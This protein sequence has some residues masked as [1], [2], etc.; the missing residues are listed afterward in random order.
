M[1]PRLAIYDIET[2]VKIPH[3][4]LPTQ[5][6]V[7]IVE[8]DGEIINFSSY[9]KCKYPLSVTVERFN[10][11]TDE[12]LEKEGRPLYDVLTEFH[13]LINVPGTLII[14]HNIHRFD[15][16]VCNTQFNQIG[17]S[18]IHKNQCFDTMAQRKAELLG[19]IKPV[20][21]SWS[22][23]HSICLT[24]RV[25]APYTLGECCKHYEIEIND[26]FHRAPADVNYTE[27]VYQKQI[28]LYESQVHK[29]VV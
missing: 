24:K 21:M 15:N 16:I 9:C 11:I 6:A 5:I 2:N 20:P 1:N 29:K 22:E 12:L 14:G 25:L 7:R 13:D 23:F 10:G 17:L 8:P 19:M 27:Q 4:A 26:Q 18:L 28:E 3:L